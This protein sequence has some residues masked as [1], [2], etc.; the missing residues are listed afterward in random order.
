[1]QTA[2]ELT[3]SQKS[4]A[5]FVA[6][7]ITDMDVA[8]TLFVAPWAYQQMAAYTLSIRAPF[9]RKLVVSYA[10]CGCI[11]ATFYTLLTH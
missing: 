9:I 11:V 7:P 4:G 3:E 8:S 2:P 10:I 5:K 1:M 6:I